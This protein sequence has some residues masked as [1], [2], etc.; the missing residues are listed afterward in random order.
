MLRLVGRVETLNRLVL[1]LHA[2][3]DNQEGHLHRGGFPQTKKGSQ[4][5]TRLPSQK[6]WCQEEE[7][8]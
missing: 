6:Y 4:L 7:I 8:P 1:N 2:A 5:H 3:A